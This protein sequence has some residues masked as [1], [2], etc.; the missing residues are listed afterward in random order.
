MHYDTDW[1]AFDPS[2]TGNNRLD[3]NYIYNM[4]SKSYDNEN[5]ELVIWRINF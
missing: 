3:L 2:E 5:G 1:Y 4:W